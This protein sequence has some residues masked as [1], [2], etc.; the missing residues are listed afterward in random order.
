M[1]S[2]K[3]TILIGGMGTSPAVLTETVWELAHQKKP[4][5]SDEIVVLATK[6]VIQNLQTEL[7]AGEPSVWK[8]LLVALKREKIDINGAVVP[9]LGFALGHGR[10]ANEP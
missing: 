2:N 3:R 9:I 4:I 1:R 5:V 8:R 7:I 6:N 10:R